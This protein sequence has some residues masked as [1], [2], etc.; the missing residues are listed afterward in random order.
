VWAVSTGQK[1]IT[2]APRRLFQII[3]AI[4]HALFHRGAPQDDCPTKLARKFCHPRGIFFACLRAQAMIEVRR[5]QLQ[6]EPPGLYQLVQSQQQRRGIRASRHGDDHAFA[7]RRQGEA[8]PFGQQIPCEAWK[9]VNQIYDHGI[10]NFR[11][12]I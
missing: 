12:E 6:G 9:I 8:R 5:C 11:F 3:A 4:R 2:S 7:F 1:L 10:L